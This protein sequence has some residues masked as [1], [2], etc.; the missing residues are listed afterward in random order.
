M[1]NIMVAGFAVLLLL[2][3]SAQADVNRMLQEMAVIE[4]NTALLQAAL[5]DGQERATLCVHC[6]GNDGNSK[7]DYIPNLAAQ[8]SEY[9]LTQ[10]EH[11]A[12]G[13]RSD[14]VMSKLA[15]GLSENDRVAIALFF[16]RQS[17]KPR[18]Q[19]V[20]GSDKGKALYDS[21]CFACHGV[22]GHGSKQYPRIA[23]QPYEFLETT[24]MKFLN[25]D[26]KRQN[27]PMMPVIR[28][29]NAQQIKEVAAHVA[30]MP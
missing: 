29:L 28:N 15:K 12:D 23:G 1:K 2:S 17:V 13:T 11:F 18:P 20:A 14:Y 25:N 26:P 30:N 22:S 9:L 8:N 6:H 5:N 19:P 16:S 10:F 21:L 3:G 24:L 7:R 4:R 27:S